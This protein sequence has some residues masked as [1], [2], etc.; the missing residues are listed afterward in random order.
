[1][2]S[3]LAP[4][5]LLLLLLPSCQRPPDAGGTPP[6][7]ST[8]RG[9]GDVTPEEVK[10]YLDGKTLEVPDDAAGRAAKP[11]GAHALTIKKEGI[12]ALQLG[13]G[14]SANSEPWHR[15]V[16]FLYA[17]GKDSY[18]VVVEIEHQAIGDKQAFFGFRVKRLVKQ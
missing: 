1:M 10:N 17:D 6:A 7:G 11:K 13:R 12:T 9:E 15:E 2:R 16:T 5:V 8:R 3:C 18:A 14:F 4:F